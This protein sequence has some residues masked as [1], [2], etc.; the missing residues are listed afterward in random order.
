[1]G[2]C[3]WFRY[4][5]DKIKCTQVAE[6]ILSVLLFKLYNSQSQ[7]MVF[8][9]LLT[10]KDTSGMNLRTPSFWTKAV[11]PKAVSIER[12]TSKIRLS[13]AL[14]GNRRACRAGEKSHLHVYTRDMFLQ[15]SYEAQ[16][17]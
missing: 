2:F 7:K 17:S 10:I 4:F 12:K 9:R 16:K 5:S 6:I 1:M 8:I 11:G 3:Q 13:P 15:R 14:A